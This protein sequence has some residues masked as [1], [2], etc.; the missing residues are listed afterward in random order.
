MPREFWRKRGP[1]RFHPYYRVYGVAEDV[2]RSVVLSDATLVIE[3]TEWLR[4]LHVYRCLPAGGR[5]SHALQQTFGNFDLGSI[6]ESYL[7]N[8]LMANKI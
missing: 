2:A 7:S 8:D 4:R 1:Q 6:K 5:G 3:C